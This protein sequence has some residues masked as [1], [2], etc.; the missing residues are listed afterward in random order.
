MHVV[1][2]RRE[3]SRIIQD[4][5]ENLVVVGGRH[6]ELVADSLFLQT[7]V[8]GPLRLELQD[9]AIALREVSHAP[10]CATEQT[11]RATPIPVVARSV[12]AEYA[13]DRV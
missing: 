7:S 5:I 9:C 6:A 10:E 4:A 8:T 13:Q 3:R 1:G 12:H 2:H 11:E